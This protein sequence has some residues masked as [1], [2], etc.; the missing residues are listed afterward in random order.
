ML[1]F[2]KTDY[3]VQVDENSLLVNSFTFE[4]YISGKYLGEV[5]R[6]IL[7]RLVQEGLLFD[8][9]LSKTL[10]TPESFSSAFI[11]KIEEWELFL[12][13]FFARAFSFIFLESNFLNFNYFRDRT[14]GIT[15]NVQN[16]IS[17][18]GIKHFT[19]DD[20]EIMEYVCRTVSN[21][22]ALLV[23]ICL[24][25]LLDRMDKKEATIAV[26][27]SLFQKHPLYRSLM[28]RYIKLFTNKK[29]KKSFSHKLLSIYFNNKKSLK[30]FLFLVQIARSFWWERQRS[31]HRSSY[32]HEVRKTFRG[33][34][35]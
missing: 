14:K 13:F 30:F 26:D 1:D 17:Q 19:T 21:R 6:V 20:I 25:V 9:K 31:R 32:S 4:K 5:V 35:I 22:S 12:F 28:E 15:E 27:G 34:L 29:V 23:S 18:L 2:I 3:D 10:D 16:I 24:S 11:S 8:G 7:V 33:V